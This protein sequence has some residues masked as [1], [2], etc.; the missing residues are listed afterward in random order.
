MDS[1]RDIE[2]V[3]KLMFLYVFYDTQPKD[4]VDNRI[5][6]GDIFLTDRRDKSPP[7]RASL[8][9][10]PCPHYHVF[11]PSRFPWLTRY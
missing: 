7:W 10:V 9:F 5:A 3:R 4:Q 1:E 8:A 2:G 6:W 11:R